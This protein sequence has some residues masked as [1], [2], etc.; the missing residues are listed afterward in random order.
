MAHGIKFVLALAFAALAFAGCGGQKEAGTCTK[1]GGS[2][3]FCS[4]EAAVEQL[5]AGSLARLHPIPGGEVRQ[6]RS[7]P[8]RLR[9]SLSGAYADGSG[10][11]PSRSSPSDQRSGNS[12][13]REAAVAR[14][15][16][17]SVGSVEREHEPR[18]SAEAV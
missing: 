9:E 6:Q 8:L 7:R 14:Q 3:V 16:V 1:S 5:R 11:I 18:L 4:S 2:G 17:G 10:P 13:S 12:A 15:S